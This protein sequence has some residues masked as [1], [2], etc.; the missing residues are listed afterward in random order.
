[1]VIACSVLKRESRRDFLSVHPRTRFFLLHVPFSNL[2]RQFESSSPA[3]RQ[4]SPRE[5]LSREAQAL[6]WPELDECVVVLDGRLS[7]GQIVDAIRMNLPF[8]PADLP[9]PSAEV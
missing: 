3:A 2:A 9:A 6:E 4:P 1:M 5:I 8:R 7:P